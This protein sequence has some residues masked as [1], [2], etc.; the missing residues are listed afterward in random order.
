MILMSFLILI[1]SK[2]DFSDCTLPDG[3]RNNS[4]RLE[5]IQSFLEVTK[6]KR[7]VVVDDVFPNQS[8]FVE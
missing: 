7:D 1:V 5:Q 4:Y 3:Q 2:H 8:L 6:G